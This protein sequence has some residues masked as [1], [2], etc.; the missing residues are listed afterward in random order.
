MATLTERYIAVVSR[1]VPEAQRADVERELAAAIADIVDSRVEAGEE[2]VRAERSALSEFGDPMRLAA[3]YAGRPLHLIGPAFYPDYLRLLRLLFSIVLPLVMVAV[4]LGTL[5]AGGDAGETAS[6]TVLTG[7]NTAGQIFFWTTVSFALIERG[8]G[9]A[10]RPPAPWNPDRLPEAPPSGPARLGDTIVSILLGAGMAGF[11]V[12]QQF[13]S[14]FTD[15]DG[16]PVALFD[17]ALWSFWLPYFVAVLL[18]GIALEAIRYRAG[19]WS[20]PLFAVNAV[21]DIA[22][23]VPAVWLLLSGSLLN[24][25]FTELL[26]WWPTAGDSVTAVSAVA[27]AA[28]TAWDLVDTAVKTPRDQRALAAARAARAGNAADEP[29]AAHPDRGRRP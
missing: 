26:A 19:G 20:W 21:L 14:P 8:S 2:P 23:A 16:G 28:V 18:A 11:I 12:W 6:N 1:G 15:A 29:R 9:G 22:F 5:A 10:A 7:L 17:P 4:A 13:R 24:P 3:D 27:V 25:A